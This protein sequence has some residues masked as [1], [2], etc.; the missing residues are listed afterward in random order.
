MPAKKTT[1]KKGLDASKGAGVQVLHGVPL[2]MGD[3][4]KAPKNKSGVRSDLPRSAIK[5]VK[6]FNPRA[7]V[8]DVEDLS[9]SI[10]KDGLINPVTV[11][12]EEGKPGS[13]LLVAGE[14]RL[15]AM[16][17]IK[18]DPVPCNI[19][20]DLE[21]DD[22]KAK[23]IAV[24]ENSEDKRYSLNY[25]EIGRVVQEL[26]D[27]EWT[28]NRIA[29]ETGVHPQ[30]V[31][32]CQTLME[33]PKDVQ[34]KVETGELSMIAGLE[35]ARADAGV[36]KKIQDALHPGI[37]ALDMKKLI[38]SAAKSAGAP[39]ANGKTAKHLKGKQRDAALVTW[40]PS[41]AKQAKL[42]EICHMIVNST[43]EEKE[44]AEYFETRAVASTILWDR[45]DFPVPHP[46]SIN[47]ASAGEG[48][49]DE[50]EAAKEVKAAKAALKKFD[51]LVA[52]EAAKHKEP[53]KAHKGKKPKT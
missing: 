7:V 14:R 30:K 15:R 17:L 2:S 26:T 40:Q 38:K 51:D 1:K 22:L 36:R 46:P 6:G 31:R 28:I 12:P 10:K 53:E 19:R 16:D 4:K 3:L 21:G 23:A 43:D 37:S 42:R 32:R 48:I 47:P 11:R 25:I 29:Q 44:Y 13:F 24:A 39:D 34:S 35:L 5:I 52:S 8:A 18:M 45:G 49:A 9:Q 20:P 27:A 41:K 50:K 33:A